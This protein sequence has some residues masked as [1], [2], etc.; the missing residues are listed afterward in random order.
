MSEIIS[1][2]NAGAELPFNFGE[3]SFRSIGTTVTVP[4]ILVQRYGKLI[5]RIFSSPEATEDETHQLRSLYNGENGIDEKFIISAY[6]SIIEHETRHFHD[7][8]A[9]PFGAAIM[10]DMMLACRYLPITFYQLFNEE[11]IALP[12]QNWHK[13]TPRVHSIYQKKINQASFKERPPESLTRIIE[14]V[15]NILS[16]VQK[17]F[18]ETQHILEASALIAQMEKVEYLFGYEVGVAFASRVREKDSS[19]IY[20]RMWSLFN[21]I[22]GDINPGSFFTPFTANAIIL[23]GLCGMNNKD[24]VMP[25]P[26]ERINAVLGYLLH[27]KERVTDENIFDILNHCSTIFKI[28][29]IAESLSNSVKDCKQFLQGLRHLGIQDSTLLK[30]DVSNKDLYDCYESW[31]NSHEYMA[32]EISN[33]PA[34]YCDPVK[35]LK[36]QTEWIPAPTYMAINLPNNNTIQKSLKEAGWDTVW[37]VGDLNVNDTDIAEIKLI[38]FN[39]FHEREQLFSIQKST[40]LS[41]HIWLLYLVFSQDLL[42]PTHRNVASAVLKMVNPKWNILLL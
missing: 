2:F 31:V 9:T 3:F 21:T 32:A 6:S 5:F 8:I 10:Q 17:K 27:S 15:T 12:L 33:D 28:P 19:G 22:S 34:N 13:L 37:G 40:L 41:Q 42:N 25:N 38:H 30:T 11:T 1:D 20:T 16:R 39:K 4:D 23:Y 18:S 29:N 14:A 35:Y 26:M 24:T 36:K 7:Y